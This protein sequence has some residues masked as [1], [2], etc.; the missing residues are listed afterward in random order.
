MK[1]R[2]YGAAN[3]I[4]MHFPQEN[5]HLDANTVP[6]ACKRLWYRG[7]PG[8]TRAR[9]DAGRGRS[10]AAVSG[11]APARPDRRRPVMNNAAVLGRAQA[12]ARRTPPPSSLLQARAHKSGGR[13]RPGNRVG[14]R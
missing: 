3:Q 2:W 14:R 7:S 11:R 1:V 13:L 8:V 4:L 12:L 10:A 9:G 5:A 6:D